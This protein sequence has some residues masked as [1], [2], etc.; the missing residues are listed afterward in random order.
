VIVISHLLSRGT[1]PVSN[2]QPVETALLKAAGVSRRVDMTTFSFS[3]LPHMLVGTDRIALLHGNL[4]AVACQT[5]PIK[6]FPL[7]FDFP[8]FRQCIQWH[9]YR[10]QDQGLAW[11][12]S[13]LLKIAGTL[14]KD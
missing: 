2:G 4:A 14:P 10:G 7:P 11:M 13:L 12:R 6:T 5:L 9:S 8:V 1:P 3:A